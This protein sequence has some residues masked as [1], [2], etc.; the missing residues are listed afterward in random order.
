MPA[1]RSHSALNTPPT[2][3]VSQERPITLF[4]MALRLGHW[5]GSVSGCLWSLSRA[6]ADRDRD[7]KVAG[8]VVRLSGPPVAAASAR[9]R[10]ASAVPMPKTRTGRQDTTV[11]IAHGA[12]VIPAWAMRW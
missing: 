12:R 1:H 9:S 11:V 2:A 4:Y 10:C 8:G 7:R 6:S 5:S 3:P